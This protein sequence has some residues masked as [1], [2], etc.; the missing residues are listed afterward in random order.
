MD[1]VAAAVNLSRQTLYLHF[2]G[3]EELFAAVVDDLCQSTIKVA[4]DALWQPGHS[5]QEQLLAAFKETMPDES[6]G[7]LTELLDTAKLLV[8]RAVRDIDTAIVAE[9]A[10]RLRH[11]F[12]GQPWPAADID[13]DDVAFILQACSYGLKQQTKDRSTYLNGM[14]A[15]IN[16]II[17]AGGLASPPSRQKNGRK[18][19]SK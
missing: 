17:T 16:L 10:S 5:L 13:V 14:K 19:E 15:E 1:E 8:P 11:A 2:A 3:K 6:I 18:G 12:D 7:L 9:I 4:H